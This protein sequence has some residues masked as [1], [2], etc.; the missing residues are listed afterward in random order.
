MFISLIL[1]SA[2]AGICGSVEVMGNYHRLYDGFSPG[3]GFDG[4]PI[5]LLAKGNPIGAILG[6][7][8]FGALRTGSLN[9]QAQAGVT[10]EIVSVIQ[11]SLIVFIAGEYIVRYLLN[12]KREK[13]GVI[14]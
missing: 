13:V 2:L 4:I 8:L 14:K 1:S 11:G 9:M 5:A 7:I 3:Y 6:S 10:D 12:R